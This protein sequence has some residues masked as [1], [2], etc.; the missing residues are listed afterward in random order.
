MKELEQEDRQPKVLE[1]ARTVLENKY[2]REITIARADSG[3]RIVD[4]MRNVVRTRR[5]W[6]TPAEEK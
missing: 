2:N 6:D 3:G 1:Q 4:I 5:W